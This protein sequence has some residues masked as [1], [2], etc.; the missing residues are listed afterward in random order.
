MILYYTNAV[1]RSIKSRASDSPVCCVVVGF[2]SG[3]GHVAVCGVLWAL[4]CEGVWL[5]RDGDG[6]WYMLGR[7]P[8][9]VTTLPRLMHSHHRHHISTRD[10]A[11]QSTF[12]G[13][14]KYKR[15][16]KQFRAPQIIIHF[17]SILFSPEW[18]LQK[19]CSPLQAWKMWQERQWRWQND[20]ALHYCWHHIVNTSHGE[21]M[22]SL[23]VYPLRYS[24]LL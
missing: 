22:F 1:P 18:F 23:F 8:G 2:I 14:W 21:Q 5:S 7:G 6:D 10:S 3:G 4:G 16:T 15:R 12:R 13:H 20:H 19:K 24:K 9:Q 11:Q 17:L